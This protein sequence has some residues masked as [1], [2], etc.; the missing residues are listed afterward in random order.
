MGGGLGA[1]AR[2]GL[3]LALSRTIG[4]RLPDGFPIG[5]LVINVLGCV[6]I[7]FLVP[8]HFPPDGANQHGRLFVIT[9]LLGGFT[10]YSAFGGQTVALVGRGAFGSA[11]INV[12]AHLVLGLGGV[13]LGA[14][15]A[16]T[17]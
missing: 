13:G 6:A 2:Y 16:K 11:A 8:A 5:T 17:L 15:L 9:G 14:W 12:A 10:T 7:G 1:A 3:D 4:N